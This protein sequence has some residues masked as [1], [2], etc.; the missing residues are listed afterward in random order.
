MREFSKMV[1]E[2]LCEANRINENINMQHG[3]GVSR[4]RAR[5]ELSSE[6]LQAA[7]R[8]DKI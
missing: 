3:R 5:I 1:S 8:I 7:R 4:R 6:S 2:V